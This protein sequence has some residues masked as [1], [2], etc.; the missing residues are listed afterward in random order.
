MRHAQLRER[1]EIEHTILGHVREALCIALS[2]PID[3][4]HAREWLERVCFLADS[5]RRHVTRLFTIEEE[6]GYLDFI[7]DSQRPTLG[8]QADALCEEHRIILDDLARVL[9]DARSTSV[10]NLAN[11]H[12]LRQ[13]IEGVLTRFDHHRVMECELWIE[14]CIVDIGGEG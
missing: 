4:A 3:T 6:E 11:L 10:D 8:H 14:A 2:S 7:V 1:L 13:K 12:S 5:F 9:A